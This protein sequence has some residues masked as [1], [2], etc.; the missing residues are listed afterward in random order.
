V[1]RHHRGKQSIV[2]TNHPS[3]RSSAAIVGCK[4][5]QGPLAS[6]F[7]YVSQDTKFEQKSWEKAE[8][9]MQELALDTARDKMGL[10]NKDIDFLF[11]GDLLNQCIS[12]SFSLRGTDIPFLGLYGA[13]STMAESLSLAAMTVDGGYAKT[14]A[15]LTSSH[16][17]GAE[18]QYRFPLAY[19]GQRTPTAQWTVTGAGCALIGQ[20]ENG[21]YINAVTFGQIVDYGISD[22]NNM[23]AAMA[24]AAY[25]T[26]RAHFDDLNMAP[27]DYD[28]IVTG[29]LGCLG[30]EIVL[31]FFQR[32][33]VDLQNAYDDCGC[34]VYDL[35]K[36]D[37]HAGGSGCGCSAVVLC[38][39]IMNQ[40]QTGR[41]KHVLFCGTGALL[42]PLSCQQGETIPGI[43]HAVS[44]GTE[45]R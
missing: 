34:M 16:F 20:Q 10:K 19:G 29:D 28:L 17:A 5:G 8:S 6:S 41:L 18:R 24:P 26:L 31:D 7:D 23:G 2:L 40:L 39:H 14:A 1:G 32:D 13:C 36:Q 33:G 44:I 45:R 42:S 11:A 35:Q 22:A 3:I 21:P 30:K 38:G 27:E 43:C 12:S 4:E 15:A 9:K 25:T 37:V